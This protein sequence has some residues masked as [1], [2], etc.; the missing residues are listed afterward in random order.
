MLD[1]VK[2]IAKQER[3]GSVIGKIFFS[4]NNLK[5]TCC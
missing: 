4:V 1:L 3:N 5:K 2:K